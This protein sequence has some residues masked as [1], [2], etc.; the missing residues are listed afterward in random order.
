[1]KLLDFGIAKLT[2]TLA[3]GGPTTQRHDRHADVHGARAVERLEHGRL[4]R[5]RLLAR[6][7]RCSRWRRAAAVR[8][9]TIAEAC[10]KHLNEAPRP[11]RVHV[12]EM[13]V[14]LDALTLRLLA[15][16]PGGRVASIE[17]L[18]SE[19]AS[20]S[21]ELPVVAE[22]ATPLPPP[23]V[24]ALVGHDAEQRAPRRRRAAREPPGHRRGGQRRRRR[25]RR[26][27]GVARRHSQC[28]AAAAA[29]RRRP[30]PSPDAAAVPAQ[31]PL[32]GWL[33]AANPFVAWHGGQWL[34]HQVTRREYRQF[35]E[36]LPVSEALRF[37][38]VNGW[39]DRDPMRPV[40]WVTFERAAAFCRAIHASLPT[41]EQWQAAAAGAWGLDPG[42]IGR[43][44]P[45]QEW[46]STVRDGLVA[47]CGGNERMSP[48]EQAAAARE[49]LMKSS[50]GLA[51]P[52]PA[53][54]VVASET[55][56]FRCVR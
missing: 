49:P 17:E 1:M 38:P 47:V 33:E 39:D 23:E 46:T 12:P 30:P 7:R 19:L 45:L 9:E 27:R 4:A 5:R 34:A 22:D 43:P 42:G 40:G 48:A 18:E 29:A 51:G 2:D 3:G 50:E 28:G 20:L 8:V 26:A 53:A 21:A 56:G 15:K 32:A 6:L 16:E 36:S 14:A 37:Q 10:A 25:D 44:G 52:S 55:I 24:D 35:L 11:I 54:N 31:P 41:S 13:P